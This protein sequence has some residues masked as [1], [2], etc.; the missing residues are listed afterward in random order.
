M[1]VLTR[2]VNEAVVIGPPDRPVGMVRVIAI[3]GDTVKLAFAFP[4]EIHVDREEVA[5]AKSRNM[6]SSR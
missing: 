6:E 4:R 1:L 5:C 2:R 3:K